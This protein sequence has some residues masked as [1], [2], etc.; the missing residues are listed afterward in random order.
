MSQIYLMVSYLL[1]KRIIEIAILI[2]KSE[3]DNAHIL[4]DCLDTDMCT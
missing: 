4:V 1:G 2:K 3:K